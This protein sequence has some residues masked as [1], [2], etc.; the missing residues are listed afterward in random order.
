MHPHTG[1]TKALASGKSLDYS[2]ILNTPILTVSANEADG[3]GLRYGHRHHQR[4]GY[5]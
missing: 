3:S 5:R 2:P 4:H 1:A